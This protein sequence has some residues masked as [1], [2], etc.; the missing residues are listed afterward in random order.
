MAKFIYRMQGV[1]DIKYKLEEQAK[2]QYM[3]AQSRLN[4]AQEELDRLF[5][6]KNGYMEQYAQLLTQRLDVLELDSCKNAI[7]IMDE[8][9]VNQQQ[10]IYRLQ[11]DLDRAID[12]LNEA[13]QER[14]IYEKLKEKQFEEFLIEL[15][16]EELKEIDELVSYQYN[17][18]EDGRD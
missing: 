4:D 1:L 16:Q 8:Y 7:L 9:I 15:N 12:L 5:E 18:T 10:V 14:K 3:N 11:T 17:N 13:M 6:R 2:Q